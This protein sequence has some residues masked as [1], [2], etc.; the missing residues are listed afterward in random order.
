MLKKFA[1]TNYRGFEN[2]IEWDLSSPKS[3]GFNAQ[4]IK[5]GVIKNGIVYGANGSGKTNLSLAV[6]DIVN[7]LSQKYRKPDYYQNFVYAGNAKNPVMFEYQFVFGVNHVA[8]E[9]SKDSQGIIVSEK[10]SVNGN[11]V[12]DRQPQYLNF[13]KGFNI[14][15]SVRKTLME[16][17]NHVSIVNYLLS[18]FPL[19]KEHY[20]LKLQKFVNSMLWFRCVDVR[21]FLGLE[22]GVYLIEEEIIRKGLVKNFA[23]FLEDVSD[24][25]FDFVPPNPN[26]RNLYCYVH[27]VPVPFSVIESTGTNSLALLFFWLQ[28]MNQ[29]SFVFIDEFDAFYHFKLSMAVCRLLFSYECQVFLS[30]HNT[31]L[32]SNDLLRPDCNFIIGDNKIKPLCN[33]TDKDLRFGHNIEKLFRG[34]A[35]KV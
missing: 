13:D 10:L 7:H 30:S 19:D 17:A 21:E 33:C 35:F 15:D 5:N 18:S 8:Y 28:R 14:Q 27:G 4:A 2:R 11:M 32:M 12:F 3:Y 20:L 16:N 1:V 6:F 29:A 26:D 34:D 23:S 25:H 22:T 24:Q 9:Y 31:Y